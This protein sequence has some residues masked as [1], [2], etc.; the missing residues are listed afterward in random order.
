MKNHIAE[1]FKDNKETAEERASREIFKA[2]TDVDIKTEVEMPEIIFINAMILND[3]VLVDN[4]LKPCFSLYYNSYLR[5]KISHQRKSRS[6]FVNINRRDNTDAVVDGMK[7]AGT[8][9]GG[10]R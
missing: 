3:K 8:L 9:F 6:E 4:G 5:L 2:D 10:G 1:Y 7:T